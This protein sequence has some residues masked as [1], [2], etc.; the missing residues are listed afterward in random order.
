MPAAGKE[1]RPRK[2][3][4]RV[5]TSCAECRRLKLRCDKNVPCGKCVSRGCGPICP[6]GQ[7]ASGKGHRLVLANTEELHDRIEI[8]TSRIRELENG[9]RALN[10][11]CTERPHPL[12]SAELLQIKHSYTAHHRENLGQSR[13]SQT[14]SSSSDSPGSDRGTTDSSVGRG[15]E[16]NLIDAFGT[17]TVGPHGDSSFIGQTARTEYLVSAHS[18]PLTKT[19]PASFPTTTPR[20]PKR[21][22]DLSF[23]DCEVTDSDL[24]SEVF[25]FLPPLS[26]A[27][28]LCDIYFEHG[29]YLSFTLQRTELLD[30]VLDAVYRAG[31]FAMM[32]THHSLSLLFSV[33]SIATLFDSDQEAYSVQAQEFHYL[34][35][36]AL[37][38]SSPVRHTTLAAVQSLLH[39]AHYVDLSDWEGDTASTNAA[40]L[41][42]GTAIRLSFGLGLHLNSSRWKLT[43]EASQ[44]RSRL[45][46]Q[47]FI[48]DTWMSFSLG[49][50]ATISTGTI[51]CPP[52]ADPPEVTMEDNG[53]GGTYF[54]WCCKYSV[55]M[56]NVVSSA[57]GVKP[58]AY[59]T[60]LELDRK[61]R[62]FFIPTALRPTCG[63][64]HPPV[65]NHVYLQ[66][67]LVLQM[68][69]TTLLNLHRAYFGQALTEK[70]DDL[71]SH[72][73]IPS[74]MATY[75]SAWRLIRGL[76]ILWRDNRHL[77]TR[78]GAV[79]SPALSAGIVMCMLLVRSP[80]SK[81]AAS[82]MEELDALATL[83]QDASNTC[84]FAAQ[85]LQP[86]LI[87]H[88]KAQQAL[89]ASV[90][91]LNPENPCNVT[92]ADLDRLGGRTHLIAA[93]PSGILA[94]SPSNSS[95]HSPT[96]GSR[97]TPRD[98]ASIADGTPNSNNTDE[99]IVMHPSIAEDMRSFD[100]GEPSLF[101]GA[102]FPPPEELGGVPFNGLT[103]T[104]PPP[105]AGFGS[106]FGMGFQ[107]YGAAPPVVL[108]ATWQSFVEQLGF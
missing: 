77:L 73:F 9:L 8:L 11:S 6:D 51:D 50:P 100:L 74:V 29:A 72:R 32:R 101:Y 12:L 88:R 64:E 105:Q 84:R 33:F 83:F 91:H 108:D 90:P 46:W 17:L 60:I 36:A 52:P 79:W 10:E 44:R 7:L 81:M 104:T 2:K 76:V 68:K 61:V 54:S 53:K 1:D 25:G 89:D 107:G 98:L 28:R 49:R 31:S 103:F 39:M 57:F 58:P 40:W 47:L 27:I 59:N 92:P 71:A 80:T 86:V 45:F 102:T 20:L 48:N 69:E 19:N 99:D 23:P 95:A 106:G 55:L 43:E 5:P 24:A 26:E 35:R 87:L 78:M 62:D 14:A 16:E 75:R 34:A 38:L 37:A 63:V 85:M 97:S 82:S 65:P 67:F 15:E 22:T 18:K 41:Y 21:I 70:P 13:D 66:R 30:D 3:P 93:P 94:P 96:T 4:G 42:M 56:H